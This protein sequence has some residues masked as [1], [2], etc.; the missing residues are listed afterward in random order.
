VTI[1]AWHARSIPE[2]A[3]LQRLARFGG[4]RMIRSHTIGELDGEVVA[5]DLIE[6][7]VDDHDV[8]K[9]HSDG[10]DLV[11]DV[12]SSKRRFPDD[13]TR[14]VAAVA[15]SLSCASAAAYVGLRVC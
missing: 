2:G 9:H 5:S 14:V 1:A 12:G 7:A 13:A 3:A 11:E 10:A 8:R 4:R 15:Q 6:E